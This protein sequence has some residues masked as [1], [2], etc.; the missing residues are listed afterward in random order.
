M[1][2]TYTNRT[3]YSIPCCLCW[4]IWTKLGLARLDRSPCGSKDA[5]VWRFQEKACSPIL[6][7]NIWLHFIL[8]KGCIVCDYK[9]NLGITS[10]I[11]AITVVLKQL[12]TT[13]SSFPPQIHVCPHQGDLRAQAPQRTAPILLQ[14]VQPGFPPNCYCTHLRLETRVC[15]AA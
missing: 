14:N 1:I 9:S 11:L 6:G 4:K 8:F 12:Y 5:T 2:N 13:I 7:Q 10:V 3:F 15:T